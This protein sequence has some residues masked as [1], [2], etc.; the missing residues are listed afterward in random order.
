M[1]LLPRVVILFLLYSYSYNVVG[2][3]INEREYN[4][5]SAFIANFI[6]YT[7]WQHFS[8]DQFRFCVSSVAVNSI[9]SSQ[10]ANEEWFERKPTF[11]FIDSNELINCDLLFIDKESSTQWRG[12]L[13]NT[14]HPN[15]LII[16]ESRGMSQSSSHINFFLAD[17]KL[18]FEIN[19]TRVAS[20]QLT[21]N[22]SLLRLAR[23]ISTTEVGDD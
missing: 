9:F 23:I 20:S 21:I 7:R 1:R 15:L 5:K 22:A 16:S 10:L 17:N 18:R 4:I 12:Y 6:R 13:K 2:V 19:T 14:E 3:G 11:I 8:S